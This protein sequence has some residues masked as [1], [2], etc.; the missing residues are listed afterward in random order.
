MSTNWYAL[1]DVCPCCGRPEQ[2]IHVGKW[3]SGLRGY[4]GDWLDPVD[5]PLTSWQEWKVWLE[6]Q[7]LL[8]MENEYGDRSTVAE[9]I[10]YWESMPLE[11]RRRQYD[12]C[13]AHLG[14]IGNS[15]GDTLVDDESYSI[16]MRDFS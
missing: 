1:T 15:L 12:W 8:A 6:T 9:F 3:P 13:Q 10:T 11:V 2:R 14:I 16:T 5:V 7:P 4:K